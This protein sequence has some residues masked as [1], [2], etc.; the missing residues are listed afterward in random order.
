MVGGMK[1]VL[2]P[3]FS[4]ECRMRSGSGEGSTR[5][6]PPTAKIGSM[7]MK[8]A[9]LTGA[10]AAWQSLVSKRKTDWKFA[11]SVSPVRQGCI[12][13]L[14]R[15][16]VPPVNLIACRS[17][18]GSSRWRTG[19]LPRH[20][21]AMPAML[22]RAPV[23]PSGCATIMGVPPISKASRAASSAIIRSGST[24][25]ISAVF[26]ALPLRGFT[27]TQTWPASWVARMPTT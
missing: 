2:T 24:R 13:A 18:F 17:E 22:S 14:G 27:A 10:A 6:R 21:L 20:A 25:S 11:I 3:R 12:T 7:I 5:L 8:A 19:R 4:K 26:S 1:I 9:W 15:P 23:S 16:V